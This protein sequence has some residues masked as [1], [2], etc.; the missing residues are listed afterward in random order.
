M[1]THTPG[2]WFWLNYPDGRK[3]LCGPNNA[4]IHCPGAPISISEADQAAIAAAPDLL[5]ACEKALANLD[6]L[7]S[8]WGDEG[9][10]R[11]VADAVQ[12]AVAKAK[13][14]AA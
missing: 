2:P 7:R 10:T 6:Y 1:S 8:T 13:G 5:A 4:V 14:G 3:L 11:T 12:A 9:V